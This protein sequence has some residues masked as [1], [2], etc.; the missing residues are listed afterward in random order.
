MMYSEIEAAGPEYYYDTGTQSMI[1]YQKTD[2]ADGWT[3][4][5]T[6]MTYNDATSAKAI[7][8]FA[9]KLLL[10]GLDPHASYLQTKTVFDSN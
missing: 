5:G 8:D 2:S 7:A 6:W 4:A 3:K 9:C 1:A 10:V